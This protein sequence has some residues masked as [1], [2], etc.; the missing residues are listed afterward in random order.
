[1]SKKDKKAEKKKA[2]KRAKFEKKY[3]ALCPHCKHP[4]H[5]HQRQTDDLLTMFMW[6]YHR[7]CAGEVDE[8][9]EDGKWRKV[10]C[11]CNLAPDDVLL[12][13]EKGAASLD[14]AQAL[15]SSLKVTEG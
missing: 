9:G 11:K 14:N 6:R 15:L 10:Y 7:D 13:V 2:K 3:A 8:R 5:Q 1:M 12:N 4:A